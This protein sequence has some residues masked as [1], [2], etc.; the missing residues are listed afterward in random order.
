MSLPTPTSPLY[1]WAPV[2]QISSYKLTFPLTDKLA[3]R[4]SS[5]PIDDCKVNRSLLVMVKA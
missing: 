4:V 1:V 5:E 2:V 3:R